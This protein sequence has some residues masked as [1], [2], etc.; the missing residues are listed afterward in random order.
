MEIQVLWNWYGKYSLSL[1]VIVNIKGYQ[2]LTAYVVKEAYYSTGEMTDKILCYGLANGSSM[3]ATVLI[4]N[5]PAIRVSSAKLFSKL[6]QRLGK[7][8]PTRNFSK[9]ELF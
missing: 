2:K 6:F 1:G 5:Y 3:E 7:L 8:N 4:E 9:S